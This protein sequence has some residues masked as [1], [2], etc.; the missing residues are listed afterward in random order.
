MAD[1]KKTV[2]SLFSTNSYEFN[3]ATLVVAYGA[4]DLIEARIKTWHSLI[5][6]QDKKPFSAASQEMTRNW[7]HQILRAETILK[8]VNA[9]GVFCFQDTVMRMDTSLEKTIGRVDIDPVAYDI[10]RA[11]ELALQS[12]HKTWSLYMLQ[13]PRASAQVQRSAA[14]DNFTREEA[15]NAACRWIANGSIQAK[16]KMRDESAK[17][18]HL[19]TTKKKKSTTSKVL[20]GVTKYLSPGVLPASIPE[21]PS[22]KRTIHIKP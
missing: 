19:D 13:M 9:E 14:G 5:E 10:P 1:K 2:E 16:W 20:D 12:D 22:P 4:R 17:V 21:R 8:E 15:L 6:D 3:N 7:R 11:A 18:V